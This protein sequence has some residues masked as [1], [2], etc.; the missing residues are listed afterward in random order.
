MRRRDVIA[1]LGAAAWPLTAKA[2]QPAAVPVLGYLSPGSA[3]GFATGLA[4]VRQGL[5]E[6]GY[7]EG[8][9]GGI[10]YR[11]AE[12]RNERLQALAADLVVRQV[13]V[14]TPPAGVAATLAAKAATTTI[15]MSSKPGWTRSL[16]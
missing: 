8:E 14:I 16:E 9:N 5:Q 11:G 13:M 4:A 2:Q 15:P 12:G 1:G 7:R 10:E 6:T 3:K